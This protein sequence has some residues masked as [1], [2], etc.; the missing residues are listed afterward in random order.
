MSN[1]LALAMRVTADA[2]QLGSSLTPVER[3]LKK[4]GDEADKSASL[5]KN[6]ATESAA[7]ASAQD[8]VQQQFAALAESL[9]SGSITAEE[10]A[11]RFKA[12]QDAARSTA[13]AFSEGAALVEKNRTEEEKR[14]E[15]IARLNELLRVGAVTQSAYNAELAELSGANAA[16][17]QAEREKQSALERARAITEANL[18]PLQRYDQTTQELVGHLQAGRISQE[19]FDAAIAKAT[20]TFTKAESAANR[21]GEAADEAGKSGTLAFNELSGIFS[22][23]PGPLGNIAGRL[24]G[25]SSASEG[26]SR[27]FSGGLSQGLSGLVASFSS[28]LNP[29]TAGIAGLTAF[30][31]AATNVAAGLISLEDRIE[32]LGRLT[33]QL[34]VSFAFSQVIEE[35][36]ARA[37]V[38]I[39]A[40]SGAFARLQNTLAGA[41]DESK[42][43][44][45]ALSRLG[46]SVSEFGALTQEAQ[47][48]LVSQRLASIENPAQRSAA[49]IALFGRSGVQLLP[50]FKEIPQAAT[51]IERLGAAVSDID[52][53][54]LADFGGG[55]DALGVAA[56][57]LQNSLLLPF[58]GLGEGIARGAAE[59][60]AG[61]T[62][63]VKP[64][65]EVLEPVLTTIGGVFQA[66]ATIIGGFGRVIGAV[67]AP[68]GRIFQGISQAIEPVQNAVLGLVQGFADTA[69]RVTEFTSAFQPVG[70]IADGI[71][72]ISETIGRIS[73]IVTTA[74]GTARDAVLSVVESFGSFIAQSPLLS[75]IGEAITSVFGSVSETFAAIGN[76]IGGTVGRLLSIAENILGI[77]RDT[78][79]PI[80]LEVDISQPSRAA[81]Q[82]ANEIDV[83]SRKAAE[84]GQAGF[85]AALKY[86]Q[87]LEE[88]AALQ[89]EGEFTADQ[90]KRAADLAKQAFEE[91]I[92]ILDREAEA[93]SKAAEE[94]QK[95]ADKRVEAARRVLEAQDRLD[96]S[97]ADAFIRDQQI[98][99]EDAQ[100][101]AAED[102]LAILRQI[103]AVE[104]AIVEARAAGDEAAETAALRRLQILDQAQAAAQEA[105]DFGFTTQDAQ[106]TIDDFRSKLDEVFT[107]GNFQ[108]APDAFKEFQSSIEELEQQLRDK[109]I[110]PGT[111]REAVDTLVAGFQEAVKEAERL[112]E[113]QLNYAE[114]VAEID[115]ERVEALSRASR[116]PLKVEDVRSSGGIAEFLRLATG[117]ED[118]AIDEARK[119]TR[120][121]ERL[122]QEIVRLGGQVEIIGA[123]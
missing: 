121:L 114:R 81:T 98:G 25:I 119:Q 8:L 21:Y 90:A 99:V 24:S 10:Y 62:A 2:S 20:T 17:A 51:D 66:T 44:T 64:I 85:E 100:T 123:G 50:F 33:D 72:A 94:A 69:V 34:G 59:F 74:F 27:V 107:F 1:V 53:R 104:T 4:L 103:D 93:Q 18:T 89:G 57:G 109:T 102:L 112:G 106:K 78:E 40:L 3:A 13:D 45:Q 49:A 29:I 58:V 77:R 115:A 26:L 91:T 37:G 56:S 65:G 5:F 54:R 63:I 70:V 105:I 19:T 84:F 30:A 79:E 80:A 48:E 108:I 83:A 6:F 101:K 92:G 15:A 120:E 32:R 22:V 60:T 16:A 12:I 113:L 117:R 9:K 42:K 75:S 86:Q 39:E 95:A 38:S 76:A 116:E 14:T 82:F 122:R 46:I 23:I 55:L 73:V 28:L 88:I 111:Y 31:A 67:L 118:P 68:L 52:R 11:Q 110:D 97:R 41:D 43:A 61:I 71:G 87:S 35:A 96:A 36:G 47:I 7:A